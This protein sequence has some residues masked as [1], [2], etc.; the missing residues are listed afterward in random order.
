[1]TEVNSPVAD[2]RNLISKNMKIVHNDDNIMELLIHDKDDDFTK[3]LVIISNNPV[4]KR[5][6]KS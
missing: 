1:V 4:E 2:K 3:A 6:L 5:F